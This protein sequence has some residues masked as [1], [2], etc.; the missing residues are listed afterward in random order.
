SEEA[1]G[2]N[3]IAFPTD[4]KVCFAIAIYGMTPLNDGSNSAYYFIDDGF[5]GAIFNAAQ[6]E[7]DN[8]G[9]MKA[10]SGTNL[11]EREIIF[12]TGEED[13]CTDDGD[14]S[15]GINEIGDVNMNV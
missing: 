13:L 1:V 14:G 2:P 7:D 9:Q 5:D 10:F 4:A 11:T 15:N 3:P 8:A 6:E 12:G